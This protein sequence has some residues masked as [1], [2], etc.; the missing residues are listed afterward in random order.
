MYSPPLSTKRTSS[1]LARTN[2]CK[3][4]V[5]SGRASAICDM[6][7]GILIVAGLRG[8]RAGVLFWIEIHRSP[9][10]TRTNTQLVHPWESTE[11][12]PE[13]SRSGKWIAIFLT[14]V[15]CESTA[16]VLASNPESRPARLVMTVTDF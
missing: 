14:V 16:F 2:W 6:S 1:V 12:V 11:S 3:G 5:E 8:Q 9:L 15:T 10:I 4:R 13:I 7:L